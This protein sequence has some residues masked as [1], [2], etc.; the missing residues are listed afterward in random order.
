MLA[1]MKSLLET[2]HSEQHCRLEF[3]FS[4]IGSAAFFTKSMK[5]ESTLYKFQIWD[6]AGQEKVVAHL[7]CLS[8]FLFFHF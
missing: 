4:S 3:L 7:S 1:I 2:L 5:L 6:T 8:L